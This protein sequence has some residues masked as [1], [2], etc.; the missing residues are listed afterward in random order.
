MRTIVH[1]TQID[2]FVLFFLFINAQLRLN[3]QINTIYYYCT[4]CKRIVQCDVRDQPNIV[5]GDSSIII[6]SRALMLF[7]F[8]F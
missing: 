6:V 7:N 8:F 4:V 3:R 5:I 2:V 1:N